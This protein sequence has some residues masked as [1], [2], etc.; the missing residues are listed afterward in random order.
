MKISRLFAVITLICVLSSSGQQKPAAPAAPA[1]APGVAAG[2]A[3]GNGI[4][5]AITTAFPAIST[6]INAIWPGNSNGNK[7]KATAT[8]ATATLKAQSVTGQSQIN[9][10]TTDLDAVTEFLAS[11]VVAENNVIAMRTTLRLKSSLSPAETLELKNEW[12]TAKGRLAKLAQAGSLVNNVTDT[13]IQTTLQAVVDANSGPI[14]SITNDLSAGPTGYPQLS[15][16]LA[17]LDSQLSAVNALA[18]V[19][20]GNVS[21]GLKAAKNA[22]TAQGITQMT[23]AQTQL[24]A[25]FDSSLKKRFPKLTAK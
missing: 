24:Q 25:E 19:V 9:G 4:K 6:I 22:G 20:I 10:I 17:L 15:V 14:E 11:C 1:P 21:Y 13:Y 12:T 16:D 23:P 2:T 3:I 8:T 7:N 5:A 18:G